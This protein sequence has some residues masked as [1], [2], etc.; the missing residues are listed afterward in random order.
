MNNA[1]FWPTRRPY[2]R[3]DAPYPGF[4]SDS[5]ESFSHRS[6]PF[7]AAPDTIRGSRHPWQMPEPPFGFSG[8]PSEGPDTARGCEIESRGAK[9]SNK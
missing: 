8:A 4:D 6:I 5:I 2:G 9:E 7:Q 1:P 3:Y